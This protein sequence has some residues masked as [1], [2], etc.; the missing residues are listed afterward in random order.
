ML[1]S[2]VEVHLNQGTTYLL[3]TEGTTLRYRDDTMYLNARAEGQADDGMTVRE[4]VAMPALEIAALPAQA[5]AEKQITQIAKNVSALV[6]APVGDAF[7]GPVLF[8]P[9]AAAQL[10]AQLLGDNLRPTRKP[11]VD[12]GR[13]F[14]LTPSEFDGRMGGRV[15]PDWFDVIDDP[16]QTTWNGRPLLGSY[17]FDFQGIRPKRVSL[18]EKGLLK[19]FL[20]TRQPVKNALQSNGHGRMPGGFGNASPAIGNLF[21]TAGQTAPLADLKA[22]LIQLCKD[23]DLPYGLLIRKLDFPFSGGNA[24]IQS[25]QSTSRDSGGSTRPVSPP[26]LAYRVFPDGREELL[27]GLRFKGMRS[28][29]LRDILAASTETAA[30]DYI[31]NGALLARMGGGGY[32]SPTTVIAPGVLFDELELDRSQE[33]LEKPPLVPPPPSA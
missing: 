8:E 32:L 23:R 21:V 28:R 14:N 30:F 18:I 2:S 5:D 1:S 26:V 16:S 19:G 27:R 11:V 29:S 25:L 24:E 20:A 7:T 22:K 10:F 31:N 3:D 9:I 15:L 17:A 6:K 4:A 12:P 13:P 33:Q